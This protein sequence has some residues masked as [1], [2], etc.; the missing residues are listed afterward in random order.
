M[1]IKDF[2]SVEVL[3]FPKLKLNILLF[4]TNN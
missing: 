4:L 3:S 1:E 2:L